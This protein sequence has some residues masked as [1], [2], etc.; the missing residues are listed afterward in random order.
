MKPKKQ[1]EILKRG[2]VEIISEEEL[3]AKLEK[4]YQNQVPLKI[5]QGFD[6]TAPD[7]HIGHC[8]SL[9]KLKQ[10]QELG[11][12]VIFLIGDFTGMIGD[13]TDRDSMRKRLTREEVQKNAE[14]YKKQIFKVL[15]P[16]KTV[17][18]FNSRWSSKLTPEEILNLT[19]HYTVARM[20]E[21]DDFSNRF[22]DGKPISILEFLYPLFQGYDSVALKA[23]VELGGTDQKF[24]LIVSRTIQKEYSQEPEVLMLMPLLEGT[25]GVQKMSKSLDNY[26]GITEPPNEIY[27]KTMSIS[28]E[29]I[30]K[31]FE[32]ATEAPEARLKEIKKILA[33]DDTNPMELKKE[34]AWLLVRTYHS[35]EE[36]D[37]A[38]AYFKEVFQKGEM[39]ENMKEISYPKG[40]KVWII[41][42]LSDGDLVSSNSEARQL[43]KSG[44]VKIENEKILDENAEIPIN[45]KTMIK[46]GKRRFLT[47]VPSTD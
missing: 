8:V 5:K 42:I 29:M 38:Q 20:I 18:D 27:G 36:A 1:L 23:D 13:P 9:R 10:F 14:T 37:K 16:Q 21:R 11:H 25:D 47:V 45:E 3:L 39:P 30:Y 31:Y 33:S 41:K 44:A 28:D 22:K 15:D 19:S 32:L 46:V 26:I 12:Q 2:T 35:Q 34:L 43:I 7:L 4:S 24:N 40:E 6:P 17:I